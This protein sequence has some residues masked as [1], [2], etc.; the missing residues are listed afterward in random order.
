MSAQDQEARL[1]CPQ[2]NFLLWKDAAEG[3]YHCDKCKGVQRPADALPDLVASA[4]RP[5]PLSSDNLRCH[6][7]DRIM[8]LLQVEE[9]EAFVYRCQACQTYWLPFKGANVL[10]RRS[11]QIATGNYFQ[12]LNESE[13]GRFVQAL[14]DLSP[15][16]TIEDLEARLWGSLR[17]QIKPE[18][19]SVDLV[20]TPILSFIMLVMM[21]LPTDGHN[22]SGAELSAPDVSVYTTL[23][24]LFRLPGLFSLALFFFLMSAVEQRI[25]RRLHLTGL[26]SLITGFLAFGH[27]GGES[28]RVQGGSLFVVYAIL[29]C[30][31]LFPRSTFQTFKHIRV[32]DCPAWLL[33]AAGLL[34]QFLELWGQPVIYPIWVLG[35]SMLVGFGTVIGVK[36]LNLSPSVTASNKTP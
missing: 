18:K 13:K 7:C 29:L 14:C 33:G 12:S 31:F 3:H 27:L 10:K 9:L 22:I 17:L 15:D 34:I 1:K 26:A 5:R 6:Q 19:T 16:E 8:E 24:A 30:L 23:V 21:Y 20:V 2:D 32:L 35:L 4:L 11:T 28:S 25:P 36:W